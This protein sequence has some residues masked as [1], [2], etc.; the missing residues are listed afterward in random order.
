MFR[1]GGLL[2]SS[3]GATGKCGGSGQPACCG[4]GSELP[5]NQIKVYDWTNVANGDT[6]VIFDETNTAEAGGEVRTITDDPYDNGNGTKTITLSSALTKNYWA[7]DNDGGSPSNPIY[8]NKHSGGF[9]VLSGCDSASNQ[10]NSSDS[11]FYDS[12]MRSIEKTF[13]DGYV[14]FYG[15]RKG[16]GAVPYVPQSW[17]D[18]AFDPLTPANAI[19]AARL[20]HI[21]FSNKNAWPDPNWHMNWPSNYFHLIGASAMTEYAGQSAYDCDFS[22]VF[23]GSIDAGCTGCSAEE[24]ANCT[25]ETTNHEQ[26]HQFRVNCCDPLGHDYNASWCGSSG[27][28]CANPIYDFEYC[29]MHATDALYWDM[30]KDGIVRLDCDDLN[31]TGPGCGISACSEGISVRTDTDPE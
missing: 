25:Q 30:R 3:Y 27:G 26:T 28:S 29:L 21:W 22:Y 20:S 23:R 1:K 5:C 7:T 16:M 6:I 10:I 15:L 18:W 31:S 24:L 2:Y 4:T 8:S 13:N 12:D 17:F 19:Y 9:G 14:E 11:C